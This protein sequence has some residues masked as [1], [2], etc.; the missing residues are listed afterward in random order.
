M[1]KLTK[2]AGIVVGI[3]ILLIVGLSIVVRSYLSSDRLK[4][5]ILPKAEAV[6]GRRVQL[7]KINVSLFKG[8]VAKGLSVKEKD[9]KEDFLKIGRFVLSYRLLPLLKKHSLSVRSTLVLPPSLSRRRGENA[10]TSATS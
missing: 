4:S 6:T 9:G 1:K 3:L 7:D 2:V 8:V 10:I 5:L